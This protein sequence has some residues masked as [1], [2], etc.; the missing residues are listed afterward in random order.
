MQI[1]QPINVA[2]DLTI[3]QTK[4]VLLF[5][6]HSLS[7]SR[8]IFHSCLLF[9]KDSNKDMSNSNDCQESSDQTSVPCNDYSNDGAVHSKL[10]RDLAANKVNDKDDVKEN[11]QHADATQSPDRNL[12]KDVEDKV[13]K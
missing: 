5:F 9:E 1:R 10:P 7:L 6:K 2:K 11:L 8:F 12:L 3:Q 4:L 13:S